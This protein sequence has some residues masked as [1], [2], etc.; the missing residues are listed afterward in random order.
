MLYLPL[1]Q[2]WSVT[3]LRA[4][5][6]MPGD[7]AQAAAALKTVVAGLDPRTALS[8]VRAYEAR[9]A[10]SIARPRFAAYLL[11]AFAAVA[12][13]LAAIG[14]YGVLSYA[15]SRRIPEIGIRVAFGAGERDVFRLLFG[16]GMRIT[17]VGVAAGL[18]L[19]LGATRMIESLLFGVKPLSVDVYAMV[20]AVLFAVGLAASYLPAR[21]AVRIDPIDALRRD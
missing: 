9:L 16:Q 19:A 1:E 5:V 15:M 7:L 18:P 6:R 10:D 12:V 20:A 2:F 17:I 4:I 13:F 21:R 11:G 8:D 14:V 3:S